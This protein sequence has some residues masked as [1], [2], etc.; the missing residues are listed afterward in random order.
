MQIKCFSNFSKK[1]NSTKQ[2]T[3]GTTFTCTLKEP[4][5]LIHPVFVLVTSNA[6]FNYIQ[7]GSRYYFVDDVILTHNN[8]TEYHC[9]VDALASWKTNIGS[10]SEFV[11][12]SASSYN[13]SLQ[14]SLYPTRSDVLTTSTNITG[15]SDFIN[16]YGTFVI[17]VVGSLSA[18]SGGAIAF[19]ALSA[20]QFANLIN[21]MFSTAWLDGTMTDMTLAT[22]KELINPF[23]YIT[24]AY[25]YPFSIT[26][27]TTD[28]IK[29]GWWDSGINGKLLGEDDREYRRTGTV[30]L[31][32]HPEASTRGNYLNC[33]PYTKRTAYVFTFGEIPLD[34]S[35]FHTLLTPVLQIDV[36]LFTG[37][38]KLAISI[39]RSGSSDSECIARRYA[40]VGVQIQIAQM[41]QAPMQSAVSV[42]GG[43]LSLAGGLLSMLFGGGAMGAASGILGAASGI[44][45]AI[46]SAFPQCSV[47][48]STGTMVD[49]FSAPK[50]TSYFYYQTPMDVVHNGRP[51]CQEKVIN[52][53]S[54]YIKTENAEV[55]IPATQEERNLIAQYMNSG[56]Y[57]E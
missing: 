20:A 43:G 19:Y 52:T 25:W 8:Y 22:Q 2:P 49:Y 42:V 55:D 5:S 41:T 46:E 7:W 17:G 6:A 18:G 11:T 39:V 47:S 10:L 48:G 56:F 14:D 9:T 40:Q 1:Q 24:S 36:D 31:P 28:S 45:N 4:T 27:G 50:V 15:F 21:Y 44:G 30:T 35:V 16:G 57:Y 38:G 29:F 12:R 37:A 32:A 26:S 34:T 54:G 3:G 23:Q 53:L 33:S 13:P 51:L